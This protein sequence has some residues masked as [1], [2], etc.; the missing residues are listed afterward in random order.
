MKIETDNILLDLEVE[1]NIVESSTDMSIGDEHSNS[2]EQKCRSVEDAKI[3][4]AKITH[5]FDIEI[6]PIKIDDKKVL[7]KILKDYEEEINNYIL[8]E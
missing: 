5:L 3:I 1:G 8:G 4:E 2:V 6:T 7:D